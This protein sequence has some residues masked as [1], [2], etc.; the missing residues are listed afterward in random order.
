MVKRKKVSVRQF[1]QADLPPR[2]GRTVEFTFIRSDG[3]KHI[4]PVTVY[5]GYKGDKGDGIQ[6]KGAVA[7]TADIANIVDPKQGDCWLAT[8][9][10][11]VGCW[12]GEE[13][14]TTKIV[15]PQGETGETGV[16][17]EEV[18]YITTPA[19]D[20]EGKEIGHTLRIMLMLDNGDAYGCD[21]ITLYHGEDG[22][23][24]KTYIHELTEA[25]MTITDN[26]TYEI[27]VDQDVHALYVNGVQ[28]PRGVVWEIEDNTLSL[29]GGDP[30]LLGDILSI[31]YINK[32]EV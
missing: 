30:F 11:V 19:L 24:G 5:D 21:P 28:Q 32:V 7:T 23:D 12:T 27:E 14:L 26:G 10:G 17:I 3:T 6:L 29:L 15:G 31:H 25:S 16:G 18:R 1:T 13:W 20:A 2:T 4:Q 9:D 22:E 8:E